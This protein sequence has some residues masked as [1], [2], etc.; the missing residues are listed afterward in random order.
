MNKFS[1]NKCYYVVGLILAIAV[2]FAGGW[3][4]N[5]DSSSTPSFPQFLNADGSTGGKFMSFATGPIDDNFEVEGLFVLDHMTGTLYCWV[6]DNRTGALAAQY[7]TNIRADLAVDGKASD[8]DYVMVTGRMD[9]AGGGRGNRGKPANTVVYVGEGN[10]GKVA[11]YTVFYSKASAN[12][13]VAQGGTFERIA[14]GQTRSA[15]AQRDQ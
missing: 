1:L 4:I 14:V 6:L 12:A 11:A 9:F 7:E 10:T 3:W 15:G 13:G 5:Q 2:G 8:M